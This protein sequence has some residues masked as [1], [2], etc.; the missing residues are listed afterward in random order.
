MLNDKVCF[1]TGST[2]GIGWA[3]AKLFAKNGAIV[4]LNGRNQEKLEENFDVLK[5]ISN[6]NHD[7]ICT[8]ISKLENIKEVYK[9]IF[10]RYKKLD[11]LVNNAGILSVSLLGM[12][13]S[14][15]VDELID[16]NLKA[17]IYNTQYASRLM[18]R[19]K[20]GSIIN[21]SSVIGT[22]GYEGQVVYSATKAG[23]IG[24]TKSASKEL[25]P[26]NIRVNAVAPGII[27]TNLLKNV[28]SQNLEKVLETIRMK[29]IGRTE[30]VAKAV[31]FF[32]SNLSEYVT[33]QV[34]SVDGGITL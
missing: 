31:L 14:S 17:V 13:T 9:N 1:I 10:N 26:Y 12:I 23:L 24:L 4:I 2:S 33:G 22:E 19:N 18:Q 25:A 21:I 3:I 16:I 6:K 15:M 28:S 30:D 5:T 8:D 29:R 34:L 20:F 11:I 32:A 7:S 27:D